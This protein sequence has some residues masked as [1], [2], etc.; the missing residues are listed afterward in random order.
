MKTFQEI[1]LDKGQ[2][3]PA[4]DL[5]MELVYEKLTGGCWHG[6]YEKVY[7]NTSSYGTSESIICG[8][9][10]AEYNLKNPPLLHSLDPW[11]PLWEG[12]TPLQRVNHNIKLSQIQT[13]SMY[14]WDFQHHHHLE[15]A[16]RTLEDTCPEC[17]GF[18][19]ICKVNGLCSYNLK[20]P[21][22]GC[23]TKDPCEEGKKKCTCNNG[24]VPLYTI[25][26]AR[27]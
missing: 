10:G 17:E 1:T 2:P 22:K 6:K 9:C 25:W 23:A 20:T 19:W 27:I 7:G 26:E 15:A 3:T 5:A 16:L 18:G 12:M 13:G 14:M 21:G 8:K 4:G 24:K 11:R